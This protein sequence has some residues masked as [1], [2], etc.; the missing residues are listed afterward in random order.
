MFDKNKEY[1]RTEIQNSVGGELQNYLP[2]KNN[3][4]LAGCFNK[5]MNPDCPYE[6]QAGNKPG[7]KRKAEK[8]I[9]QP[10][11]I[12]P[13][14]VKDSNECKKYNFV[15]YFRCIGGSNRKENIMKAEKKS[16]R[17]GELAYVFQLEKVKVK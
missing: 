6:I 8:L 7:V 5:K 2:S 1:T 13:V 15:G 16:G 17:H 10:E 11:T 12:F 14:F 9:S 3:I 4:I